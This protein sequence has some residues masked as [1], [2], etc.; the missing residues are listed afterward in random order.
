[1]HRWCTKSTQPSSGTNTK[2]HDHGDDCG[3]SHP[4]SIFHTHAHYTEE[5]LKELQ[6]AGDR[7]NTHL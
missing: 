7:D 5:I 6:G 2:A 3:H 4:Y 1:M